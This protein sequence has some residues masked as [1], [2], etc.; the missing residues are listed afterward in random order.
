MDEGFREELDEAFT[1]ACA[2]A[3]IDRARVRIWFYD[4]DPF[5]PGVPP[6]VHY[7][8]QYEIAE[9]EDPIFD[10][11][12][13]GLANSKE[14]LGFHRIAVQAGVDPAD[15]VAVAAVVGLIRHEVEHARQYDGSFGGELKSLDWIANVIA[16]HLDGP[17]GASHY[18][19][20]PVEASANA[21]AARFL[22]ARHPEQR[23]ELADGKFALFAADGAVLPPKLV[24]QRTVQWIQ[25]RE[26]AADEADLFDDGLHW[27]ERVEAEMPGASRWR[28]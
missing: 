5:T 25:Q 8:P 28:R 26:S 2:D 1:A 20:K 4:G 11:D 16:A 27:D 23:A 3:G 9:D 13:H 12:G 10:A 15:R 17:D 22:E 7:R 24:A 18:R 19:S 21:A 14:C 6:S